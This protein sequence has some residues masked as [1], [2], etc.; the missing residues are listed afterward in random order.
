MNPNPSQ[1]MVLCVFVPETVGLIFIK[2]QKKLPM[3]RAKKA[4]KTV[5]FSSVSNQL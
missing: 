5:C 4:K 1:S 2:P 3:L